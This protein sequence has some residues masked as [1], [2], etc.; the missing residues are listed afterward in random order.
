MATTNPWASQEGSL[1]DVLYNI[2]H[3]DQLGYNPKSYSPNAVFFTD[4]E[5]FKTN[6][7]MFKLISDYSIKTKTC[8]DSDTDIQYSC[9]EG[10]DDVTHRP[11]QFLQ[12]AF[13]IHCSSNQA[14]LE[15]RSKNGMTQLSET[16]FANFAI[17]ECIPLQNIIESLL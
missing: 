12:I 14:L 9:S 6:K 5:I 7:F 8:L 13:P 3:R 10:T 11:C 16:H 4:T 1:S 15:S 2:N 17:G